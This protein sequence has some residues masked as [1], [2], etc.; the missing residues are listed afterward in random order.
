MLLV[1]MRLK[2][3]NVLT[4]EMT[5][6]VTMTKTWQKKKYTAVGVMEFDMFVEFDEDDIPAGMDEWEYARHLADMGQWEEEAHGGDFRICDV[7][8]DVE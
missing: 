5:R 7:M 2:I 3:G 1:G 4:S 8:E 6:S